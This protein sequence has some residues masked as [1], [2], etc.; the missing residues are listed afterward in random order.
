[1][2]V[3]AQAVHMV[4][5]L[6]IVILLKLGLWSLKPYCT[7]AMC[8]SLLK[9]STLLHKMGYKTGVVGTVNVSLKF[10]LPQKGW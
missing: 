9:T 6:K 1:M 10:P 7:F 4:T 2:P 5:Y 8:K 3:E